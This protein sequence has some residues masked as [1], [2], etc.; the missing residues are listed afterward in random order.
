MHV[1]TD[2]QAAVRAA[3][4]WTYSQRAGPKALF[5]GLSR[6]NEKQRGI[7]LHDKIEVHKVK[8]HRTLENILD[9][10]QW[11]HAV[12]NSQAD[13]AA[14]KGV[15]MHLLGDSFNGGAAA[16][17]VLAVLAEAQASRFVK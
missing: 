15:D 4:E 14:A 9:E 13:K 10:L 8:A 2:F 3:G 11:R 7:P 16:A 17:G 12:G 5:G 1:Q 6:S